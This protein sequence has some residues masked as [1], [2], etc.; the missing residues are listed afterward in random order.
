MP[1][2]CR[3]T[4]L[5]LLLA[6]GMSGGRL[7]GQHLE[8]DFRADWYD[9]R[10]ALDQHASQPRDIF[11]L[12]DVSGSM[13]DLCP[14]SPW[15]LSH[16]GE[17]YWAMRELLSEIM[18][19]QDHIWVGLVDQGYRLQVAGTAHV[20]KPVVRNYFPKLSLDRG[21]SLYYGHHE[22]LETMEAA[23]KPGHWA[24][25]LVITDGYLDPPKDDAVCSREYEKYRFKD[26]R[27]YRE[28]F[29]SEW[30]NYKQVARRFGNTY[31]VGIGVGC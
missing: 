4:W 18:A 12:L 29:G 15:G 31:G 24:C 10:R 14:G 21:T 30:E 28:R 8:R 9:A 26:Q 27:D 3:L 1:R 2:G 13:R 16:C 11:V 7:Y 5:V 17:A 23:A 6:L 20:P 19:D 22:A 25:I